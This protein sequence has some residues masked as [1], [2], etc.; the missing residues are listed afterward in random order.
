MATVTFRLFGKLQICHDGESVTGLEAGK[1]Y[2]LLCYLLL[3]RTRVHPRE[4]LAS[5]FWGDYPTAHAKKHLRQALWQLQTALDPAM[6]GSQSDHLLL[7]D[8]AWVQLNPA[9][10]VWVDVAAF[11]E[12]C[13]LG[14]DRPGRTLD[15]PTAQ[16][17]RH[18]A[19]LYQ[20]DLLEGCYQD[21]CLFERER[22][23]NLYLALLDRLVDYCEAHQAYEEGR[24]YAERSLRR[25]PARERAHRQLMRL[26]YLAGDRTAA[27]HQY[28][29]CVVSLEEHLGV[30]PAA[31]TTWL[32]EQICADQFNS[33]LPDVMPNTLGMGTASWAELCRQLQQLHDHLFQMLRHVQP[34]LQLVDHARGCSPT[35]SAP[36][37]SIASEKLPITT[38]HRHWIGGAGDDE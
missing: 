29:K 26:W 20:G 38:D 18:A 15:E 4:V 19:Q 36:A 10:D 3:H 22:L 1:L 13:A 8:V 16:A 37:H 30:L 11:E 6:V 23:Q 28:R 31:R 7:V 2:E 17:L 25:D 14:V 27:L 35:E 34:S 33:A 32:Y 12:A 9:V 5:L 24:I 21:W